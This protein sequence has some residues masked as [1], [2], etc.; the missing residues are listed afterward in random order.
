V[1]QGF[2]YSTNNEM[3]LPIA[4]YLIAAGHGTNR[5]W[6]AAGRDL[7]KFIEHSINRLIRSTGID[8]YKK[9]APPLS[10]ELKDHEGYYSQGGSLEGQLRLAI[11]SSECGWMR[12]GPFTK[13]LERTAKGL[14]A[15]FY[16]AVVDSL[17]EVGWVFDYSNAMQDYECHL[18]GIAEETG[19]TWDEMSKKERAE[20]EIPDPTKAIPAHLQPVKSGGFTA[21]RRDFLQQH[22]STKAVSLVLE[23]TELAAKLHTFGREHPE[24]DAP[25]T[26]LIYI[27][28]YDPITAA[29][30]E[31]SQH[32]LEGDVTNLWQRTFNPAKPEELDKAFQAFETTVR[33]MAKAAQLAPIPNGVK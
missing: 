21:E 18:D 8:Q 19:K 11:G 3:L 27:N 4:D 16:A 30:D 12:M 29:F 5:E 10:A 22:R 20:Y 24:G 23:M 1:P 26:Y 33:L 2:S 13:K 28:Q 25:C 7:P 31:W 32:F 14:G 17:Y 9:D 6:N 15:A